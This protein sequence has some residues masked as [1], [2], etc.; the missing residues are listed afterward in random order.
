MP[1][2]KTPLSNQP[3]RLQGSEKRFEG[4]LEVLFP[5][6]GQPFGERIEVHR[7]DSQDPSARMGAKALGRQMQHSRRRKAMGGIGGVG[8][9][10]HGAQIEWGAIFDIGGRIDEHDDI[11]ASCE[12]CVFDRELVVTVHGDTGATKSFEAVGESGAQAVVPASGIAKAYHEDAQC[13]LVGSQDTKRL[14]EEIMCPSASYSSAT[15]GI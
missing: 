7:A 12:F 4:C 8:R 10:M 2:G 3:I 9:G 5:F 14:A 11:L 1:S 6:L 15:R 13:P